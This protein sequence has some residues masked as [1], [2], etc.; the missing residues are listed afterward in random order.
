MKTI[1]MIRKIWFINCSCPGDW[2][3]LL[4]AGL[5]FVGLK[6][7]EENT[8]NGNP[9]IPNDIW[10]LPPPPCPKW[11][12]GKP[13]CAS[14]SVLCPWGRGGILSLGSFWSLLS[15]PYRGITLSLLMAALQ[16]GHVALGRI[17]SH[18]WRHGQ[19]KRCPQRLTTASLAVSRHMLHSN[20]PLVE[21][22]PDDDWS[23]SSPGS[24]P[25]D[26][27]EAAAIPTTITP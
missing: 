7:N 2:P 8:P 1:A 10:K 19:Q 21:L 16:T 5:E 13:P 17:S 4:D 6:L 26:D 12:P 27:E 24:E 23:W 14:G 3:W 25:E 15:L 20:D 9:P 11:N 22:A 18:W